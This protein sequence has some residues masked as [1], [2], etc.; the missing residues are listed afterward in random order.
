MEIVWGPEADAATAAWKPSQAD[1]ILKADPK[2]GAL[3]GRKK[4]QFH[5]I[6]VEFLMELAEHYG[7]NTP[8]FGGK[9]P[10]RNW[11]KGYAWSASEDA[12]WRHFL[13]WKRGERIDRDTGRHHLICAAWHLIALFIYDTR[14]L[15][16]DDITTLSDTPK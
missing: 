1:E 2:T 7:G 6:P 5:L 13:A 9:Y 3:K 8:D 12:V 16:T 10:A 15:G 14:K 11:E 4:A